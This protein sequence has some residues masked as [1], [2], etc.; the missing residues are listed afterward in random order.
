M[1]GNGIQVRYLISLT[2]SAATCERCI[3][4]DT[5]LAVPELQDEVVG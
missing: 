2:R 1:T 5:A 3:L 4:K